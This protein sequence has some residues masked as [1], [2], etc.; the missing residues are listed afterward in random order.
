[1]KP[2][3]KILYIT[4][5]ADHGG[6]PKHLLTL[7]K[8]LKTSYDIYVA[9]PN[10]DPYFNLFIQELGKNK[11]IEIPHRKF[12]PKSLIYLRTFVKK[13]KID[14]I[15][16]HGKGAGIYSRPLSVITKT[17]VIHTFHGL[18]IGEYNFLQRKLYLLIEKILS[19]F[20]KN[21]IACSDTETESINA[22]KIAARSK[23]KTIYNGVAESKL[24]ASFSETII[25]ST[26]TRFDYPKNPN[27]TGSICEE[28]IKVAANKNIKFIVIG[29][30][31]GRKEFESKLE[32]KKLNDY[33]IFQG[34]VDNPNNILK[35]SICYLS[36]SRW[37]GLPLAVLEAMSIGL[38][39][40]ATDVP[41]NNDLIKQNVNG[42]LFN[43]YEPQSAAKYI[44][45]LSENEKLWN[46][47]SKSNLQLIKTKYSEVNMIKAYKNLYNNLLQN[48]LK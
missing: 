38:P 48:N 35:E 9:A 24:R 31:E 20:T 19:F 13:N 36:T 15:H 26:I 10:D 30:G 44:V 4:V 12:S 3:S 25:I 21:I 39:V 40:I 1:M 22:T 42:F 5:R 47:I 11:I 46:D 43:L 14:L 29:E 17:K 41:G 6:G 16:S 7:I 2:K 18:H 32:Q 27:L 23:I 37:E 45:E 33:F 34:A 28:L 8:N